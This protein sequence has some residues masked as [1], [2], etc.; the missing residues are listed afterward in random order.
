MTP[1]GWW[2]GFWMKSENAGSSASLTLSSSES[3]SSLARS[4]ITSFL[5]PRPES[6]NLHQSRVILESRGGLLTNLN[7]WGTRLWMSVKR[8]LGSWYFRSEKYRVPISSRIFL[9]SSSW[10]GLVFPSSELWSLKKNISRL[11]LS[12]SAGNCRKL[13]SQGDFL[14]VSSTE[15]FPLTTT[16]VSSNSCRLVGTEFW[17]QHFHTQYQHSGLPGYFYLLGFLE[18]AEYVPHPEP[19]L[20]LVTGDTKLNMATTCWSKAGVSSDVGSSYFLVKNKYLFI[21]S[22]CV[23]FFPIGMFY[24]V[25]PLTARMRYTIHLSIYI[26]LFFY[27]IKLIKIIKI[28]HIHKTMFLFI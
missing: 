18:R 2:D 20:V 10:S 16:R 22:I 7:I 8:M 11:S 19:S 27:I 1:R 6:N 21:I 13:C 24:T 28:I 5:I 15:S 25:A 12:F 14:A 4:E 26:N 3:S 9:V 23:T 17:N